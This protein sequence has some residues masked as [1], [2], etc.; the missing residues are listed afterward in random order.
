MDLVSYKNR[1]RE[2]AKFVGSVEV[3]VGMGW[4]RGRDGSEYK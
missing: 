1:V 3:G 4:A 2:D